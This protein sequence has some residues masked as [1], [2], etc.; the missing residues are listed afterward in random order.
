MEVAKCTQLLGMVGRPRRWER[1]LLFFAALCALE[2]VWLVLAPLWKESVTGGGYALEL[3]NIPPPWEWLSILL[4]ELAL[5]FSAALVF[6][7]VRNVFAIPLAALAYGLLW[8][9][10]SYLLMRAQVPEDLLTEHPFWDSYLVYHLINNFVWSLL[11]FTMLE[12][13]LRIIKILPLALLAGAVANSLLM[14]PIGLLLPKLL[15]E[16]GP[17]F[18]SRLLYL[19]F[20]I[21]GQVLLALTLWGGLRLSS[22]RSSL[23]EVPHE[24]RIS[25]GFYL[26]TLAATHGVTLF[27]C[28]SVY[29]ILRFTNIWRLDEPMDRTPIL[30]LLGLALLFVIYSVVVFCLLIYNMWATI[31]DGYARTTPGWA[32]GGLF[33]PFYNFYWIFQVFP[34][35]ATDYNGFAWRH[36]LYAPRLPT[37]LFIAYAVVTL[38]AAFPYLNLLLLPAGY[39]LQL[40]M[41][42]QICR[43]V[44]AVPPAPPPVPAPWMTPPPWAFNNPQGGQY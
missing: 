21:L 1:P 4:S 10:V 22:G 17:G 13:A 39:V 29:S 37:G 5:V 38:L 32:V 7:L 42:A 34:G 27:I 44:N 8:L 23:D 26:G 16:S 35:F 30:L 36:G 3:F 33:I 25:R 14:L 28:L 20:N 2:M 18:Q 19:F 41:V 40:I 31:Q 11:L 6:G 12:L 24:P 15:L 9:G 43:A